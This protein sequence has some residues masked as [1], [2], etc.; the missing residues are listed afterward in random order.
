MARKLSYNTTRNATETFVPK[1][2]FF[3]FITN[4]GASLPTNETYEVQM[5]PSQE[6]DNSNEWQT[7]PGATPLQ[8]TVRLTQAQG[9]P[10][11]KYRIHRDG[12]VGPGSDVEFYWDHVTTLRSVNNYDL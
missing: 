10:G 1:T 3:V 7:V 2:G 9:S 11:F 6:A 4:N 5:V 12:S 8:T